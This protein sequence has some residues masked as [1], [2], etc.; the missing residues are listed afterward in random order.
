MSR[1]RALRHSLKELRENQ[2]SLLRE[3]Q[4]LE[5]ALK[6]NL[7]IVSLQSNDKRLEDVFRNLTS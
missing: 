7:N 2:E 6:N 1:L 3:K 4:L 5:L